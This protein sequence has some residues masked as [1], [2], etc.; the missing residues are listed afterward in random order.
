VAAGVAVLLALLATPPV[1]AAVSD[2][3]GF[4]SVVVHRGDSDGP[5]PSGGPASPPPVSPG[6]SLAE[7]AAKVD[8][9]VFELP[10]LGEPAG[11]E[12]S[13]DRR[14]LSAG[15]AGGIRLDQSSSLGYTFDKTSF[16]VQRVTVNG[17]EAIWFEDSHEVALLDEDGARIPDTRRT[18][19]RTLIWTVGDTTLRLEGNL[20]LDR[21]L[22]IAESARPLP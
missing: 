14:V 12:V 7:A 2:W 20:S 3:F 22:E 6:T 5:S 17:R 4:G 19:G 8:F 15:W 11:T 10:S 16:S 9:V 13:R 18:A 21:A 1:R